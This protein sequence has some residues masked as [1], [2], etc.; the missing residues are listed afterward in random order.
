MS[1]T[2]KQAEDKV[3]KKPNLGC[4]LFVPGS[5]CTAHIRN[6]EVRTKEATSPPE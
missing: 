4:L 3:L 6:L 2:E 1:L 5:F